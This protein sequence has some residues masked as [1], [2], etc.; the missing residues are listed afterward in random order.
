MSESPAMLPARHPPFSSLDVA[1]GQLYG[2]EAVELPPATVPPL[3]ALE[4]VLANALVHPPC[5]IS[6]SGGRDSSALLAVA[7]RVARQEGLE[8]PIP[9]TN[10]FPDAPDTAE[11]EWQELVIGH[12][13]ISDWERIEHGSEL[14]LVGPV[15]ASV[16]ARRGLFYPPNAHGLIPAMERAR[17]GSLVN[18][19][20]GDLFFG[21][22]RWELLGAL[23]A[24][25]RGPRPRDALRVANAYAPRPIQS[26]V[27][28]RR[29]PLPPLEW[30]T[31]SAR[32]AVDEKRR[33]HHMGQPIRFDA[34]I[35]WA[36]SRRAVVVNRL[37][38][39]RLG[40]D[41]G[42]RSIHAFHDP[43]FLAGLAAAGGRD[44]LGNRTAMMS[45]LFGTDLPD[46]I[47]ARPGKARFDAAYYSEYSRALASSWD[48]VGFDPAI[49]RADVLRREWQQPVASFRTAMLLQSLWLD[50]NGGPAS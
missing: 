13:G 50:R 21:A 36:V 45:H 6:F 12:L 11:D 43:A 19:I 5:V 20:D 23:R 37:E 31:E 41:V 46:A 25:R 18:G 15:A 47:L 44:G 2:E 30:L 7:T 24:R 3:A 42:T 38:F 33:R 4:R 16:L 10:R 27:L 48:G 40:N 35:R 8:L 29:D 39:E 17:G 26:Q 49:V 34:F 28:S 22:W 9:F 1:A 32:R 14:D